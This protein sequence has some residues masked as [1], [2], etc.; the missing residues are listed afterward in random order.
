MSLAASRRVVSAS[1]NCR[2]KYGRDCVQVVADMG[3][4]GLGEDSADRGRHHLRR[5][6][7]DGG[8]HVAQ[9]ATTYTTG[10]DAT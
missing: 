6:L 8:E 4:A 7:G 10:R 9:D 5:S 2:P 1:G 3:G